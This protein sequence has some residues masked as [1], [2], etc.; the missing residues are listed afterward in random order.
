MTLQ[1]DIEDKLWKAVADRK[2]R[3][4]IDMLGD[5][6]LSTGEIVEAFPELGRTGVMKHIDVLED[7]QLITVTREG[8]TRWNTLNAKPLQQ[9]CAPWVHKRIA[10]MARS[11]ARLKMLAEGRR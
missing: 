3:V 8:R 5:G 11:A 6:P 1:E 4:I 10:K 2:R 9:V 7:A